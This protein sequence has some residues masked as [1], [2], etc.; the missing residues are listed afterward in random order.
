MRRICLRVCLLVLAVG[1]GACASA[2]KVQPGVIELA[3]ADT[4]VSEGCYDCLTQA[5]DIYATFAVGKARPSIL[6]RLFETTVLLGLRE[7]ELAMDPTS[8]FDAAKALVPELPAT[9]SAAAYLDMAAAVLP[10]GP[11]TSRRRL[12]TLKRPTAE[13]YRTWQSSLQ[14]STD[15]LIFRR[16]LQVSLD[17][18]FGLSL[19]LGPA[20]PASGQAAAAPGAPAPAG[21]GTAQSTFM[22]LPDASTDPPGNLLTYRRANCFRNDRVVLAGLADGDE[23]FLE[24][25]A[26][27]GRMRSPTPT[28]KE[29]ADAR[30]WLNG[31][32]AKWPASPAVSYALGSLHQASGDCRA[33]LTQFD[34]TLALDPMHEPA[35]LGRLVCLSYAKQHPE[36]I[37]QAGLMIKDGVEEGEARYWRAWNERELG[38]LKEARVDSDRMKQI[39][40]NDRALTL[41]GQ[42][43]HDMDDLDIAEKDLADAKRL[44]DLNC[45]AQWYFALVKY[46]RQAWPATAD[47]FTSSMTCYES[48]VLYDKSKLDEMKK[49]DNVDEQFRASQI[50]GFEAAIKDDSSQVSASAL[51][52]A[53]NF[54]R[55]NNREK[56]LEY[57]DLAAK[58]PDRAKQASELRALI[59]K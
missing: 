30:K 7:K 12:S 57:C 21:S 40:Y 38:Q 25:G 33:A 9:Y 36:A 48:A 24:A 35:Q 56:A 37:A 11:G 54:A 2:P 16:Y 53:V 14:A 50:A 41:A 46:K 43:E 4:L 26:L 42:I 45:I 18:A 27:A 32:A 17:C 8:R 49:A 1:V 44:N 22:S 19:G 59:V 10:D 51:N 3:K 23:R 31:A 15:S 13:Q 29:M 20:R 34:R 47:A 28:S 58:D 6:P 55:A 5:R 52:A 39:L